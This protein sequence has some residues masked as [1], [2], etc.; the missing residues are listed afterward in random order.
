MCRLCIYHVIK[1]RLNKKT[2]MLKFEARVLIGWLANSLREPANQ[3]TKLKV[4]NFCFNV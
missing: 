2:K 1:G 3:N 4:K